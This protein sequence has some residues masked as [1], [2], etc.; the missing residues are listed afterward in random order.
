MAAHARASGRPR[1]TAVN[2]IA[3]SAAHRASP[4]RSFHWQPARRSTR[5]QLRARALTRT[6]SVSRL[7]GT[8]GPA[9]SKSATGGCTSPRRRGRSNA[10]PS[11][12]GSRQ[13]AAAGCALVEWDD[14]TSRLVGA[15]RVH[16]SGGR[17]NL[18]ASHRLARRWTD[19]LAAN[20]RFGCERQCEPHRSERSRCRQFSALIPDPGNRYLNPHRRLLRTRA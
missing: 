8:S 7:P 11:D 17:A 6:A 20:G 5:S 13:L 4:I 15:D 18:S 2:R 10:P 3:A 9:G 12:A 14:R 19:E 16:G 1:T